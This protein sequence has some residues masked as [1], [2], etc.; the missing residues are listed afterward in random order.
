MQSMNQWQK[1][2]KLCQEYN[3]WKNKQILWEIQKLLES[4][5]MNKIN[6]QIRF[7]VGSQSDQ[8]EMKVMNRIIFKGLKK[9]TKINN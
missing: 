8:G 5:L 3:K 7:K 6:N 4:Y 2:K 1:I 9:K